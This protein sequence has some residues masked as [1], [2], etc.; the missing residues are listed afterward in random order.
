MNTDNKK[1]VVTR[2]APSPTGYLHIGGIRTS[3]YN[4]LFAK[5]HEGTFYVRIEDTDSKRFVKDAEE[6]IQ[7][8]LEWFGL[9]PDAAPWIKGCE[10][11]RQ[12]ERDYKDHVQ[13]LLDTGNAYYAFDTPEYIENAKARNMGEKGHTNFIYNSKFRME[14]RNSLTMN[15]NEIREMLVNGPYV[16]RFKTPENTEFVVND[17]IRGPIKYNTNDMDDKVLVKSDGVPTY[18]LA[19]CCD[20][21]DM[22]TTHVIRGEEWLPSMGLHYLLYKAMGWDVPEF[23]HLPLILNPNGKGKLSKRSAIKLGIPVFPMDA[24]MINDDGSVVESDGFMELGYDPKALLNFLVLLGWTPKIHNEM[25]SMEDM[26][27]LFELTDVHL[28]GAKFDIEKAKYFNAQYISNILPNSVLLD[29]VY[30]DPFY[31]DNKEK[32]EQIINLAKARS[33]LFYDL[34]KVVDI[35][36]RGSYPPKEEGN[37]PIVWT[38][39]MSMLQ[40]IIKLGLNVHHLDW[41]K[42]KIKEI[43]DNVALV[44]GQKDKFI[45]PELRKLVGKGIPGPDLLTIM[46]ILGRNESIH[47]MTIGL[48]K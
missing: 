47:R 32:Q 33:V 8:S 37:D 36:K 7:D 10:K 29:K 16:I 41:K 43:L 1:K 28:G 31:N 25:M 5:K 18:H 11:Y 19:N 22:G 35:F 30:I 6:F 14:M 40:D 20:D 44:H 17:I 12:S 4:Y 24:V 23:A 3:L 46:E 13:K 45:M 21:H 15:V 9:I 48:Y 27:E 34:N 2:F 39:E 26:I 42:E 38:T